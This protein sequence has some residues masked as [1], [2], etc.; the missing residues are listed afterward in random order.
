M[1]VERHQRCYSDLQLI[2]ITTGLN[3]TTEDTDRVPDPGLT[4]VAGD[5]AAMDSESSYR[6]REQRYRCSAEYAAMQQSYPQLRFWVSRCPGSD[7][8]G[9]AIDASPL[10]TPDSSILWDRSH[11]ES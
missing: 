2:W 6:E 9:G 3:M 11:G 10:S 7:L 1:G 4:M 5:V 8:V